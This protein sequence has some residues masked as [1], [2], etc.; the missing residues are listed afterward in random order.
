MLPGTPV[1]KGRRLETPWAKRSDARQENTLNGDLSTIL[2][3][4]EGI[5][6]GLFMH[7]RFYKRRYFQNHVL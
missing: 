3:D 4:C 2:E 6:R 5:M 7:L 1:A